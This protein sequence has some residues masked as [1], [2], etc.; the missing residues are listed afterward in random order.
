MPTNRVARPGHW[1]GLISR[2]GLLAAATAIVPA[3]LA[4]TAAASPF[5][6]CQPYSATPCLLPFPNNLYTRPDKTSV[7]GLR[8]NLPAKA[9]PVNK[10]GIAISPAPYDHNDGF[11]PGSA[12]VLHVPGLDNPQALAKTGAVGLVNMSAEF[13]PKQ[14]VVVIDEKT[15]QRQLV[16]VQL[17]ANASSPQ[18]TDLMIVPGKE[19]TDG[20]TYIV[21]LR[22]LRTATGRIIK[23]PAWFEK[24]RDGRKLPKSEKSQM[25]RSATIYV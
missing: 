12:I 10:N 2:I 14:P 25:A 8:L 5:A 9:M 13:A 11:S 21:A 20:H 23:A 17:D 16:Y 1:P 4:A 3:A 24:L 18:T 7:T 6:D 15:G 19:F 22:S